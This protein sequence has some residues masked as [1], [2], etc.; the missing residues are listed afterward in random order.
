MLSQDL[1]V[2]L[3]VLCPAH[4]RINHANFRRKSKT[5]YPKLINAAIRVRVLDLNRVETLI[6]D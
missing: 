2:N 1:F 6:S 5:M 3:Y 4:P